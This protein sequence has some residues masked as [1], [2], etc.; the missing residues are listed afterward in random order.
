MPVYLLWVTALKI[1]IYRY[2]GSQDVIIGSPIFRPNSPERRLNEWVALRDQISGE[3]T[4]KECLLQIIKKR[5]R[6]LET[7]WSLNQLKWSMK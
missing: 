7:P 3:S 5:M 2:T 6:Q 1:L 4:F